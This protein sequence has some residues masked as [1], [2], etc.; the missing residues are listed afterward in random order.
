VSRRHRSR[1]S[2]SA[3]GAARG[4]NP[5]WIAWI[6]AGRALMWTLGVVIDTIGGKADPADPAKYAVGAAVV[7]LVAF[8]IPRRREGG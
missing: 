1:S 5:Q 4:F 6:A 7:S 2:R 3:R 8:L